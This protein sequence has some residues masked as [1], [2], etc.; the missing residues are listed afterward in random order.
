MRDHILY[1]SASPCDNNFNRASYTDDLIEKDKI[2]TILDLADGKED[3]EEFMDN[4]DF[5]SQYFRSLYEKGSVMPVKLTADYTSD[6]FKKRLS[7]G[8]C[9]MINKEGPYLV[10]CLE[11][12]DRTGF[13]VALLE[14]LTGAS[15]DEM[16]TDYMIS[17][18]NYF[19][20]DQQSDPKAYEMIKS[21]NFDPMFMYLAGADNMA[22]AK[23]ADLESA[24]EKYLLNCGM[25]KEEIRLLKEK[26]TQDGTSH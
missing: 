10:N 11:G 17:Y 23:A 18:R 9:L 21:C 16:V 24:G 26:L 2:R 1:R 19:G 25:T 14:A 15:Y 5:A 12:K 6:D 4:S 20:L 13:V 7:G 8:L 3:I 22:D